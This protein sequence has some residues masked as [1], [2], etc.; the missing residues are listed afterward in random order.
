[1]SA[2]LLLKLLSFPLHISVLIL[3]SSS[4]AATIE[5][6]CGRY[7]D[8]GVIIHI[9]SSRIGECPIGYSVEDTLVSVETHMILKDGRELVGQKTIELAKGAIKKILLP[10]RAV[11]T[12]KYKLNKVNSFKAKISLYEGIVSEADRK[13]FFSKVKEGGLFARERL[14]EKIGE[15][16][17]LPDSAWKSR[18]VPTMFMALDLYESITQFNLLVFSNDEKELAYWQVAYEKVGKLKGVMSDKKLNIETKLR[19]LNV[20]TD[21]AGIQAIRVKSVN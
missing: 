18:V 19:M 17:M 13:L 11:E 8:M 9:N 2:K 5:V 10:I 16:N 1:M 21:K 6:D 4:I 12:F 15:L 20:T 7:N 3:S 14:N